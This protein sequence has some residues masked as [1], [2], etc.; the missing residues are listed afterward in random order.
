MS[1]THDVCALEDIPDKGKKAIKLRGTRILLMRTGDEVFALENRC[2]HVNLPLSPG[3]FDGTHIVCPFHRARFCV[4]TGKMER[5]ALLLGGIGKDC[6][7]TYPVSIVGGRVRLSLEPLGASN[8]PNRV[9]NAST[10]S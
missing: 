8:A 1:A 10:V 9:A 6:V 7:P 3:K 2:S 5:K 4:R